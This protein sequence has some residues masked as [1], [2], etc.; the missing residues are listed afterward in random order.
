VGSR[1]TPTDYFPIE[2]LVR[3]NAARAARMPTLPKHAHCRPLSHPDF[4]PAHVTHSWQTRCD[5]RVRAR[6]SWTAQGVSLHPWGMVGSRNF[7]GLTSR[8]PQAR[9]LRP[10]FTLERSRGSHTA[11]VGPNGSCSEC[12][13]PQQ[14]LSCITQQTRCDAEHPTARCK[15]HSLNTSTAAIPR[16]VRAWIP[17]N[18][19]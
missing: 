5:S 1:A 9:A 2:K 4:A 14:H 12:A 6:I 18:Q 15:P 19:T 13:R 11:I 8:D 16:G 3:E 10:K 7:N 17:P